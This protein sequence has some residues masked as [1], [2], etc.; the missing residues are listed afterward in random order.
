MSGRISKGGCQGGDW[1]G[2]R[3]GEEE[4]MKKTR[5]T[6]DVGNKKELRIN[7]G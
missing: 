3:G 4:E 5:G 7:R 1:K 6:G 2:E